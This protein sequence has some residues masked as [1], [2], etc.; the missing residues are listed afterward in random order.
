MQQLNMIMIIV[1]R[2]NNFHVT[3]SIEKITK[4]D[5]SSFL[6]LSVRM[7]LSIPMAAH[8]KKSYTL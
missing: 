5:G 6:P 2:D 4:S 1:K 3:Q 8:H 7:L